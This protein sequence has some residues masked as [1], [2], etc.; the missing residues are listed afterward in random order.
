[1]LRAADLRTAEL[2]G[3][4]AVVG[5][6]VAER[7]LNSVIGRRLAASVAADVPLSRPALAA[8]TRSASAFTLAVPAIRSVGG[9]IQ[10]GDRVAVL[11]TFGA[12]SG[13]ARTRVIARGL[14]VLAVGPND[15][16]LDRGEATVPVTVDAARP[17][18]RQQ[19]GPQS[20]PTSIRADR[21]IGPASKAC[22]T[23]LTKGTSVC[24]RAF[25]RRMLVSRLVAGA[26]SLSRSTRKS[27]FERVGVVLQR[28]GPALE[29]D[30]PTLSLDLSR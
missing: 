19:V 12:S 7:G 26:G 3:D 24:D 1:V 4:D 28:V 30:P 8:P 17:I 27:S 16:S 23:D 10:P 20:A 14:Q 15:G 25:P 21:N 13:D 2:A 6:A 29:S 11:A 22:L 9:S 18:E 5:N